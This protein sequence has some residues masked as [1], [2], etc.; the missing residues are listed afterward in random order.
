M[1]PFTH[2]I[3]T[4]ALAMVVILFNA[5]AQQR[6]TVSGVVK[7]AKSGDV[8]P[9]AN[10]VIL[11]STR[12]TITGSG[13]EFSLHV[14]AGDIKLRVSLVGYKSSTAT[15]T[16]GGGAN[17]TQDFSLASDI[18][19]QNEVVVL[20]TR[21]QERTIVQSP[22][23][24][25]I[26]GAQEIQASGFTQTTQILKMLVPSYN[27]PQPSITDGTDHVRPATLRGLGPDQVL[28][29]VNGKRRH[30]S[31]LVHVNGSVGRGSSGVDLNAVPVSAIERIEVLRDGAAAQYGSDAISGVINI[32]LKQNVG[33]DASVTYGQYLSNDE[34]GYD[35]TEG[36]RTYNDSIKTRESAGT[37]YSAYNGQRWDGGTSWKK[38]S[39]SYTDGKSATIH[40]GYGLPIM[41]G[42]LYVSGQFR[43]KGA[44]DRAGLDP[45]AQFNAT[46]AKGDETNFTP[47]PDGDGLKGRVNHKYGES[48]FS[49]I[50]VF[51]N[52]S[53]P[54][55]ENL[56][57][58]TFGGYSMRE[59]LSAGYYRRANDARN[60][61]A[62]YPNGFLPHILTKIN[63]FSFVGG[64]KGLFSGWTYDLSAQYG[65]N[66]LHYYVKHSLNTSYWLKSPNKD[67]EFDAGELGFGQA[68]GN[69]DLLRSFEV[70]TA[71]PM[72]VALGAEFRIENYK[73]TAGEEASYK[74]G[75]STTKAAGAQVFPGFSPANTQDKSRTNF[76]VYVDVENKVIKD[77]L[78]GVAARFEN[79]SDFGSTAIGKLAAKY[80]LPFG[81]GVRGAVST[82]FRAPS[83]AQAYY[84][85]IST[86]FIS[87]VPYEIGTFP[88]D[89]KVA[90]LLGAK[91]LKAEKSVN[92]S[93]GITYNT[94]ELSLTVD[95]YK[96]DIT[97]RIVFTEN[98]TGTAITNFLK[99]QGVNAGG[100][101]YF[102]NAVNT[103]TNGLD[104]TVRYGIDFDE[105]GKTKLTLAYNQNKTEITNKDKITT[106]QELKTL[107]T[108]PI[109]SYIEQARFET[110]QP[111][112]S[113]NAMVNH[114][115]H[116]FDVM[117]RM[118]RYGE[119]T[120]VADNVDRSKDQTY[121]AK[122]VSDFEI[123]Y[124]ITSGV[125]VA[126]GSNN[127]FDAYPD[128]QLKINSFN[129]IF[130]YSGSSPFG[131]NGRFVY[132]RLGVKM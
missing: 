34:R 97:D 72:T 44:T 125:T 99:S 48:D 50:S 74:L 93:G 40:L 62:I 49:D 61:P 17:T 108:T 60:V 26:I 76:G 130:L 83:L 8:L 23:P 19:G 86:N 71:E 7:D 35:Q 101:R 70:G 104:V 85:A 45:R 52:G 37:D 30:T 126:A 41:D 77:L 2:P 90:K 69:L 38:E 39:V 78:L 115:Y 73:I 9:G 114:A 16:T 33:M 107:T 124:G 67:Y 102:T 22:V 56:S 118:V 57:Y 29:L 89:N 11:G 20:G 63:D 81:A 25:D 120:T 42:S 131:F 110:A 59:G 21:S 123:S 119:I 13:G 121:S 103:S 87:G 10:I 116:P 98:F 1:K 24:I 64:L 106:P 12:G 127:I 28:I 75:D 79:Y 111:K 94:G 18:I 53:V 112:N 105:Y 43:S 91:N 31:A 5:F 32:V 4:I 66:T 129:G 3:V 117:F 80:D 95:V 132:A 88:V 51:F 84:S 46:T 58:Y 15:L 122:W 65:F 128:K 47:H 36:A 92:T 109:F 100:G 6:A 68:I 55:A 14:P 27:A 82:G 54:V 96:I 113:I